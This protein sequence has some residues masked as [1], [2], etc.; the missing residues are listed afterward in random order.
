MLFKALHDLALMVGRML[1]KCSAAPSASVIDSQSVKTPA[2][3]ERGYMAPL[4]RSKDASVIFAVN[5]GGRLLAV[6]L[7]PADMAD[8]TGA[9]PVLETLKQKWLGISISLAMRRTTIEG[10]WIMRHS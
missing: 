4:R 7:A 9:R 8:S 10:S 6:N 3:E 2:A 1:A 5:T